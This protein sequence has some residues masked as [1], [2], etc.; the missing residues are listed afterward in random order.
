[1]N[2]YQKENKKIVLY[3]HHGKLCSDEKEIHMIT[4]K[5]Q[6]HV[7][8]QRQKAKEYILFDIIY[9]IFMNQQN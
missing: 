3:S 6:N 5:S 9:M 7:L 4:N 2:F 1:M 8:N